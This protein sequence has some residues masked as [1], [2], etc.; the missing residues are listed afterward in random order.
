M[1]LQHFSHQHPLLFIQEQRSIASEEEKARCSGCDELVEGPSYRCSSECKFYLHKSCAELELTP[2]FS[3]PFHPQHLLTFLPKSPYR[4][5]YRCNFCRRGFWGFDYH[6]ASCKFDL[7]INCALLE[8]SPAENFP[9]SLHNHPLIFLKNHNDQLK[10][11]CVGCEKPL[12]GPIYVCLICSDFYLHKECGELPLEINHPYDRKHPLTLL[13]KPPIHPEKCC[14]HLCKIKWKGFV[15]CC[16]LCN[17]ELTLEDV[18]APR[19]ITAV[20]HEHPWTLL[21]RQMSF[22][23]DFCGTDGDRTPYVCASCGLLVHKNCISLPSKIM[24]TRHHHPISHSH[25]LQQNQLENWVC[26]ICHNEVN[27]RYGSYHCSTSE[28]N[29]IAHVN[30]ATDTQIWDGTIFLEDKDKDE[31]SLLES[32]EE[33]SIGEERVATVIKHA[34]HDHNLIL[35]SSGDIKEDNNCDGCMGPIST[36][37]YSCDNCNFFL[38]KNCAELPRKRR[39]PFHKHLLTLISLE[40][41]SRCDACIRRCQGFRYKCLEGC[42]F[43]IDIQCSLLSDTLKHPS[44]EH[45][46]FLVPNYRGKCSGCLHE[47]YGSLAYRCTKRCDFTLDVRCVKLPLTAWYKYDRHPLTLTY[48]GDSYPLQLY[49]DLCEKER[50]PNHWFYYC[51]DC[52]NSL[53]S[54]CA[55]GDFPLIKLGSKFRRRR[56]PHP[57]TVVKNIWNCP[58]CEKCGELCNGQTLECKEPECNLSFHLRCIW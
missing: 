39:H 25:S 16:S 22:I 21:P 23:C 41:F 12:S 15:Y 3:H 54:N 26:R 47:R 1:E 57:L 51:A 42:Y 49:C 31:E 28:C 20:S 36:P 5:R 4:G 27:T 44:H 14:C 48:F 2:E 50:H 38:H 11:D 43:E 19:T 24:I 33:K 46:L 32:I 9:I 40:V 55:V 10:N 8:S 35:S 56:H 29:Y 45:P 58:R 53:H 34:Y 7:D 30:C 13:P 37:F 18:D 52:D 17:F 6:C